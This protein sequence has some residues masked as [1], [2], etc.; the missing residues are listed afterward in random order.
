MNPSFNADQVAAQ[1]PQAELPHGLQT[2]VHPSA[3]KKYFKPVLKKGAARQPTSLNL[4]S[5]LPSETANTYRKGSIFPSSTPSLSIFPPKSIDSA[6][7]I[8]DSHEVEGA[9]GIK[10]MDRQPE[11]QQKP[12]GVTHG[13]VCLDSIELARGP[14]VVPVMARHRRAVVHVTRATM[15]LH[16]QAGEQVHD[17]D[18]NS[19]CEFSFVQEMPAGGRVPAHKGS[20]Q[21][22]RVDIAANADTKTGSVDHA[23]LAA[24]VAVA[25][26]AA[27]ASNTE[28]MLCSEDESG[29]DG[30]RDG[31]DSICSSDSDE[32]FCVQDKQGILS[33]QLKDGA[34]AKQSSKTGLDLVGE[35]VRPHVAPD[36]SSAALSRLTPHSLM[37]AAQLENGKRLR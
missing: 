36:F 1:N 5:A 18:N 15:G 21:Q 3:Q 22:P 23:I 31:S 13:D 30:E 4:R 17:V 10:E 29:N 27:A 32:G 7:D 26:A 14:A 12:G 11:Q 20:Q 28:H 9:H 24:S 16:V 35:S 33:K 8:E 2:S 6:D 34:A 25:L 19:L 37:E